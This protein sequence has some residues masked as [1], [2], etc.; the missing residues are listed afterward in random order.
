MLNSITS[1]GH[2]ITCIGY[3]QNQYTLIFNDPYGNKNISYPNDAGRGRLLRLAGLQQ[4]L[5][6][7]T[8]VW[9]YI[10][11]R[12]T[13]AANTN[14]GSYWDLNGATAGAGTRARA[15]P[16]T[17]PRPIGA[18]APA[19]TVATGP[20]AGT[21]R[22][23]LRGVGCHRLLHDQRQRHADVANLF[24]RRGTVTFTGGQLYFLWH[25]RLLQQLR[26]RRRHGDLQHALWRHRFARQM[27]AGHRGL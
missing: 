15:A 10:Y 1:A 12:G 13:V 20:W 25:R 27:G 18:A 11:A 9:R 23:L 17:R 26:R 14:W 6:N 16:G 22:H 24:V 7:L 8:G 21:E 4:R 19:A 5:H 2:Y 3:V